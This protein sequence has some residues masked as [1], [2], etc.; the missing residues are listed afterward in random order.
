MIESKNNNL[1]NWEEK[2]LLKK[3]QKVGEESKK[4]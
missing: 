3:Q 1:D 4:W 2:Y